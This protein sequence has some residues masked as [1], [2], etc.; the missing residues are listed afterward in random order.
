MARQAA[1]NLKIILTVDS[2]PG[3]VGV[4]GAEVIGDHTLVASLI[5]EVDVEEVEHSG[6]DQLSLLVPGVVLHFSIV[7]HLPVLPPSRGHRRVAAAG[8]D[9]AQSHVVPPQR[10]VRLWV[11]CDPRLGEIICGGAAMESETVSVLEN[12]LTDTRYMKE[13]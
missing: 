9:A 2:E 5:S 8:R 6:V 13:S 12:T 7:Q 3:P 4:V 11:S 1:Y 10:H